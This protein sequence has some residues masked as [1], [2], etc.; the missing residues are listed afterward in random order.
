MKL[1]V[2]S[3]SHKNIGLMQQAAEQT[4]P[5]A[6]MHLGDHIGDA[7]EL[8]RR[9]P[10]AVIY[11][12]VGN[13]DFYTQGEDE[14]LLTLAGKKIYM[15]HGHIFGVKSGLDSLVKQAR[16]RNADI[17]LFGHTHQALLQQTE[18]LWLM[19]PGHMKQQHDRNRAA[20]Y[21]IVTIEGG[22]IGCGIRYA[23]SE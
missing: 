11:T 15:T 8:Q 1:L 10:D 12:V 17:A 21:G 3:D 18:G 13:C 9:L 22:V 14:L 23:D 5:D 7:R 20:S 4:R 19:N 6:I 2:M 16:R